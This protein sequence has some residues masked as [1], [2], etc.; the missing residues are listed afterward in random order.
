MVVK[1]EVLNDFLRF[2]GVLIVELAASSMVNL[3][4]EMKGDM[5]IR[6]FNLKLAIDAMMREFLEI[7]TDVIEHCFVFGALFLPC[8]DKRDG[9]DVFSNEEGKYQKDK[10]KPQGAKGKDNGKNKLAYAFKPKIPSL[11]KRDNPEK[12][13][14]LRGSGKLKHR[15]LSLYV[16]NGMRVA[17]EAIGSFDLVLPSG[18]IIVL[19]NCHFAPTITRGVVLISRLV[20]NGYIYTFTNYGISVLKENAFY[21]N[22]IPHNGIY[23]IDMHNIY[24]NVS[25]MF[26]VSNKKAKHA[27]DSSY[28]WHCRLSYINKKHMDKLQRDGILQLTH[29]ESLKKCKSRIFG[30]MACKP[31]PHQVERAKDLLERIHIDVCGFFRTMSRDG[32]S[33]FITL[34]MISV[35]KAIRSDRGGEYLSHEFVNHMKIYG[36]VSQ[37]TLPYAPQ[38]NE[39]SERRNQ[40]LLDMVRSI[41]NL[42]TLPKSFWGYALESAI[43]ILNMVPTKK[44]KRTPYEIWHRKAP[45]LSYL[46]VWSWSN[47][48]L[49]LIQEEDTQPSENTSE[50]HNEFTPIESFIFDIDGRTLEYGTEDFCLITGFRFGKVNLD[51]DEEDHSES[52]MRVFP[53]IENL[54]GE[55]LLELVSK[56]VKFVKLDDEDDVTHSIPVLRSA[57]KGSSIVKSVHTRVWTEIHHEVHVRTKVSRV[58]SKEESMG[59]VS[60]C[61]N[62]DDLYK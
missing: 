49:E 61:M 54:K 34:Q 48:G 11:P 8:A 33:Y 42:T 16:G 12:D 3:T 17:V 14:G 9:I 6:N 43:R 44:V 2:V 36:I 5:I 20:N 24:P 19:D 21:F 47:E 53:K 46:R 10:K 39:V 7:S 59:G 35:I 32:A 58:H 50:V 62:V 28:L 30:K 25:S 15:A 57:T 40:T 26:N 13:F 45:K 51:P 38:H 1:G 27:L 31:F 41:L 37:L 18:L 22:A 55:H 4:L 56:D 60:Q 23:E 29:Y 52:H